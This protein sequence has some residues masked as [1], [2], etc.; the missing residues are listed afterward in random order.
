MEAKPYFSGLRVSIWARYAS[1]D[2]SVRLIL[3]LLT[4]QCDK[5]PR[6][7]ESLKHTRVIINRVSLLA[8]HSPKAA[9]VNG[10]PILA[11]LAI[12]QISHQDLFKLANGIIMDLN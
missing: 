4:P 9:N 1:T 7:R 3:S 6:A 5:S 11:D 2:C 10:G 12:L 8:A